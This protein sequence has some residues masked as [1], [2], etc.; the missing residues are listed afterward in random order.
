MGDEV[1]D[2]SQAKPASKKAKWMLLGKFENT[3][4]LSIFFFFN[5]GEKAA[6]FQALL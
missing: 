4:T 1:W 5:N 2:D 6:F 3:H